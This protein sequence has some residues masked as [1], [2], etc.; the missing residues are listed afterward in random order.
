M[1]SK[2]IWKFFGAYILLILVAIFVL[3]FL[4]GLKLRDYYELQISERLKSNAL[5]VGDIVKQSVV[6]NNRM[7]IQDQVD[8]LAAKLNARITVIDK[9]GKVLGDSEQDPNSMEDHSDR[10]EVR[11]ALK[12][13]IGE[14]NRYSD[15][16]GYNMKY[17][18]VP[19]KKNH[20]VIGIVRLA[21]PLTE[22]ETQIQF[23]YRIVMWGGIIAII[24]VF[25]IGYFIS[26]SIIRPISKMKEVAQR[27]AN[28]DFSQRI[29]I[30]SEDE[31]GSLAKSLNEM[32]NELQLKINNLKKLDQVKTD[33]VANVSHEL[34]TPLTAISGFIE[35]L[36]D[37]ALEDQANN[38]RFL[39]IIKKHV[40]RLNA[41]INDLLTLS[42]L[43]LGKN[44]IEKTV[45]DLKDLLQEVVL[46][47]GHAIAA[48]GIK[49]E[50]DFKSDR[51]KLN[52]D[53]VKTEQVFVNLIDNAVKYTDDGGEVKICVELNN[54]FVVIAVI[55][56]GIGI[57]KE[58]LDRVFERFYMADKAR[59][60]KSGST[61]LGLAIVKHVVSLHNGRI[62]I[63]RRSPQGTKVIV[64]LPM[65]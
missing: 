1:K 58:H 7:L 65:L 33:F 26:Q 60:R 47:F 11:R 30:K 56:N 8:R 31:L 9:N 14:S 57:A 6:D 38:R 20:E 63:E 2:I 35:T 36:E 10:L 19:L 46:G 27:F 44:R 37:G 23:I 42:E 32:A 53:R 62:K 24:V 21:L 59:S 22:I 16:L 17:L 48:K 43:E 54:N 51:I 12:E 5:L 39:L 41:M 45:F 25:V 64:S 15:T 28:A 61:G 18:A 4:V 3:N 34:K 40:A 50:L 52:A 29:Y 55:D 13:G 49:L